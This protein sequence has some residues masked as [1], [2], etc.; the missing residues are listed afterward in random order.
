[1][2]NVLKKETNEL[3]VMEDNNINIDENIIKSKIYEIRGVQ[4]MLDSD[5]AIMYGCKNGT[6]EI[7]QAVK[8]NPIKFPSEFYF[9]ITLEECIDISRSKNLT[10]KGQGHNIKY[11]PSCFTEQGVA[12]LATIIKSKTATDIN[13]KI[14][15]AFVAM[16]HFIMESKDNLLSINNINNK[17][18]SFDNRLLNYENLLINTTNNTNNLLTNFNKRITNNE[19]KLR[20]YDNKFNEIFSKFDKQKEI[21]FKKGNTFSSYSTFVDTIKLAK[22]ELIII[23]PYADITFLN[24]IK[25]ATC[26][27]IIITKDSKRLDNFEIDKYNQ[28]YHNL[29]VKRN[30]EIHDRFFILDRASVYHIGTSINYAGNSSFIF[31]KLINDKKEILDDIEKIINDKI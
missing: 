17:L 29:T 23:D 5:L 9:K 21:Y 1:M 16:R 26:N 8:N 19:E 31:I 4:V 18:S 27:V 13:I 11:L 24:L 25:Y 10:L 2:N 3:Q 22:T 28:E 14:M 20:E 12:M 7:N 6:K 15:R 30:N